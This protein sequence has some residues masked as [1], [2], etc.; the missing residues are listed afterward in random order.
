M[1][2]NKRII[3]LTAV[4]QIIFIHE[5]I[6]AL[7]LN[8]YDIPKEI[9]IYGKIILKSNYGP[10]NYGEN[11][12]S[13]TI[14]TYYYILLQ[15]PLKIKIN[16]VNS[17]ITEMQIIFNN[18]IL[19]QFSTEKTYTI[20]GN[21]FLATTGHHHTEVLISANKIESSDRKYWVFILVLI[22]LCCSF[23]IIKFTHKNRVSV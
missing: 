20:H 12:E 7:E 14:E 17:D 4:F 13:D 6:F 11:P 22:I 15:K 19:K 18:D 21:L 23:A 8:D 1:S 10:P 16:D 5:N 9:T 3:I 2:I